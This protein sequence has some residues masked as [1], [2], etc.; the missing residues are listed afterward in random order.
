MPGTTV[1]LID[2]T[3][4]LSEFPRVPVRAW[5]RFD[6]SLPYGVCLSFGP[7]APDGSPL[8]WY[9]GR[10]LLSE[11]RYAPAGLGDVHVRP[12]S[13]GRTLV[14]LRVPGQEAVISLP[15]CSVTAFLAESFA[16]VPAGT[17]PGVLDLDAL[18]ARLLV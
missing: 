10:D 5:L 3:L 18:C 8:D 16:L 6:S 13:P 15:T 2:V 14:T 9:F 17:E 11:G 1:H 12:G 7:S 4:P